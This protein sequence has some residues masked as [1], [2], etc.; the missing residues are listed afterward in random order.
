MFNPFLNKIHT[1]IKCPVLSAVFSADL[2][3]Q[4]SN[5]MEDSSF[6]LTNTP[7]DLLIAI[8]CIV[9]PLQILQLPLPLIVCGLCIFDQLYAPWSSFKYKTCVELFYE[10]CIM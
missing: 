3:S 6:L 5:T 4:K 1:G 10:G 7:H 9:V 2:C 8:L